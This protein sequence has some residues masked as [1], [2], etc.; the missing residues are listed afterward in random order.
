MVA[1]P[2]DD[3]TIKRD[4]ADEDRRREPDSVQTLLTLS[5]LDSMPEFRY[6]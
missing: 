4:D 3:L 6:E 1:V 2:L 5:Q